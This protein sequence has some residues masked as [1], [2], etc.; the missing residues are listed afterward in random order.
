MRALE[1]G[2]HLGKPTQNTSFVSCIRLRN[3]QNA[4]LLM[5]MCQV[6]H[7]RLIRFEVSF[8]CDLY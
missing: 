5:L 6:L 2:L 3:L 1:D 8:I 4:H 7:F